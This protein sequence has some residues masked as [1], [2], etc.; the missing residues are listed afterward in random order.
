MSRS[1][2]IKNRLEECIF[3]GE[4][5]NKELVEIFKLT[6]KYLNLKTRSRYSESEGI[7]YPGS[8]KRKLN[9]VEISGIEFIINKV[10]YNI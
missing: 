5:E 6:A 4:V 7:S 2:K 3:N 8:L 10:L 9:T 1:E